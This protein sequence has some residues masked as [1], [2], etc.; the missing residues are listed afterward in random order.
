MGPDVQDR[1]EA[2]MEASTYKANGIY[3]KEL[4][5]ELMK[6]TTKYEDYEAEGHLV[7]QTEEVQRNTD[8]EVNITECTK[9]LGN[10]LVA[11][12]YQDTTEGSS[13]FDDNDSGVENVDTLDDSEA[14]SDFCGDAASALDF[15]GF[16]EKLRMRK[17]KLT[18][19]WRSFIQPLM[20]RCKWIEVKIKKLQSQAQQYDRELEAYNKRKQIQSENSTLIDGVKS[21]PFSQMNARNDVLKRKKRRMTEATMDVAAYMS[22]H[23]LFS[24][25]ENRKCFTEGAFMSN[26]S[27]NSSKNSATRKVNIDDEFWANDELLSF[28][29]G[30]GD[31]LEHILWKIEF[32]QSQASKLKSRVDRVIRENAGKFSSADN[33]ILP[34]PFN[35]SPPNNGDGMAVGT[36]IASQLI[37]EYSMGD[38]LVPESAVTSHG[39]GAP[40]ANGS[41]DHACF[42]DA[43]KNVED[44]VLI[45]NQRVKEDMHNFEEVMIPPIQKPLVLK[46]GLGNTNPPVVAEPDLP[47]DD[48]PPPKIRSIAKLT[49]PK[50]KRKRGRRKG[51]GRRNRRSTG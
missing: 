14:L 21:L 46:D 23:N 30:D 12:E 2:K 4:E 48:Q 32:L 18:T 40:N 28:A 7:K 19:H 43:Y 35:A 36:Y 44:G 9:S 39:D 27:K 45:D 37:S 1:L 25:Y 49:A 38:V 41:I 3:A 22:H 24:Y 50:S 47:T 51:A 6:F 15:D 20:W 31:N 42:A 8:V 34:M 13:S 29:P 17:K 33:L 10:K 26:E 11:A 16:G 5:D